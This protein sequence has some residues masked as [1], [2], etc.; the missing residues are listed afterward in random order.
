MPAR[1]CIH[2]ICVVARLC[3]ENASYI[4]KINTKKKFFS[5]NFDFFQFSV[6]KIFLSFCEKFFFNR[7]QK[8]FAD[9]ILD[10]TKYLQCANGSP[11]T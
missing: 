7:L 1:E 11:Y 5:Q 8:T 6:E 2:S 4:F 9:I 10:A 3:L